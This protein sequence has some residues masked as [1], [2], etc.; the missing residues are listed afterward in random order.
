MVLGI[1]I[2]GLGIF[3]MHQ[4]EHLSEAAARW[5]A[6]HGPRYQKRTGS[7]A[8]TRMNSET[9]TSTATIPLRSA[10]GADLW[11]ERIMMQ[12]DGAIES[13]RRWSRRGT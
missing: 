5:V 12:L 4:I 11:C 7:P 10:L 6:L 8:P 2:C 13:K 1:V 3:R 9:A